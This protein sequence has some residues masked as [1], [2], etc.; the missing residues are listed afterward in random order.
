VKSLVYTAVCMVNTFVPLF[1][2]QADWIWIRVCWISKYDCQW[3]D[4]S[5]V[6][7]EFTSHAKSSRRAWCK[8]SWRESCSSIE[9]LP[10][11]WFVARRTLVLHNWSVHE[12]G[13]LR[14]SILSR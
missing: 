6:V 4:V 1:R 9:L 13:T 12:M 11:S 3:K 10:Q 8:L 2:M 7:I 14:R 5:G